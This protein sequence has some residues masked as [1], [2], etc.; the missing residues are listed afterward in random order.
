MKRKPTY[1]TV[2]LPGYPDAR[3]T[4]RTVAAAFMSMQAEIA[5]MRGELESAQKPESRIIVPGACH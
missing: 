3:V 5:R 1:L 2:T 4:N